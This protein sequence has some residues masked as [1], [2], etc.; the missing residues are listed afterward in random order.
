MLTP[1]RYANVLHLRIV[2]THHY[3]SLQ[4]HY[5]L[6][7]AGPKGSKYYDIFLKQQIQLVT[8]E[9]DTIINEEGFTLL[10]EVKKEQSIVAAARNMG[11]SYRKAWGLLREI[12]SVLGLQLVGKHRGGKAGGKTD[13]TTEGLEL[14]NAYI[15]LKAELENNVHDTV[16]NFFKRINKITDKA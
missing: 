4:K 11:I 16:K 7:M 2:G 6:I 1:Y 9:D 5:S 3:A 15:D 13:L 8:R 10:A 14:T 12:E